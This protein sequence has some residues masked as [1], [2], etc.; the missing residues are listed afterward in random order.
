[1]LITMSL[2][3]FLC[4]VILELRGLYGL[5]DATARLLVL[6]HPQVIAVEYA[7]ADP[8]QAA[9]ALVLCAIEELL[10]TLAPTARPSDRP[11][12]S[13]ADECSSVPKASSQIVSDT[14]S[15]S[16]VACR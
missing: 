14:I 10:L 1:M 5:T 16:A 11:S 13:P 9:R 7:A 3:D 4:A 12:L 6:T 8:L 15:A 2:D